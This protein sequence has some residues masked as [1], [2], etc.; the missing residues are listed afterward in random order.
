MLKPFTAPLLSVWKATLDAKTDEAS[1]SRVV[2][3]RHQGG[4]QYVIAEVANRWS[5]LRVSR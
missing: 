1:R 2:D 3:E 4:T 5:A